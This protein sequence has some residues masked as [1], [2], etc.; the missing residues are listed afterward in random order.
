MRTATT[1]AAQ[2]AADLRST[3]DEAS[4]WLE[5]MDE[6]QV[7]RRPA[8]DVWSAREVIGH[9]LDSAA[10]NHQRFV[11]AQTVSELVLPGYDQTAWV[12][13]QDH[14][15]Q[16]WAALVAFWRAYNRHLAHVIAGARPEALDVVCR[17]GAY[18]PMTLGFVMED[19][20]AHQRHHLA[21]IRARFLER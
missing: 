1:T 6:S 9:L 19:Y 20:V 21:Q 12:R 5:G 4:P 3:V 15:G 11:L 18:E 2:V 7:T 17:I 14:H 16:P 8:P 10:N 13:V